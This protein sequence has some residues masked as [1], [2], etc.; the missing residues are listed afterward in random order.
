MELATRRIQLD[1][2]RN[3]N[4]RR[5]NRNGVQ[6]QRDGERKVVVEVCYVWAC[7]ET[8]KECEEETQEPNLVIRC[9]HLHVTPRLVRKHFRLFAGSTVVFKGCL[10]EGLLYLDRAFYSAVPSSQN[11]SFDAVLFCKYL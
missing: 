9:M 4:T 10:Q 1:T 3:T 2:L 8:H 7:E 11:P 5:W 6:R